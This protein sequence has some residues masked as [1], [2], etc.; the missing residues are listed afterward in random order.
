MG[1][2]L[3]LTIIVCLV[4]QLVQPVIS[5]QT[6][7]YN[8][9]EYDYRTA[10][11]L[12][13]KEK[14]TAAMELFGNIKETI[15]DK[16]H[17]M[18]A[19]CVY[20]I[21]VCAYELLNNDAEYKLTS[22]IQEF[23]E[24]AR[25][26]SARLY[27]ANLY[28]R[29]RKYKRA[30]ELYK[31][32]DNKMLHTSE[33]HEFFFKL[34]YSAFSEDDMNTA[35]FYF[36]K[37]KDTESIYASSATYYFAHIAYE[38]KNYNI[39][40]QHFRRL[41]TDETFKDIV[42]YYI[43]QILYF[44]KK[45]DEL[46]VYVAPLLQQSSVRRLPEILKLAAEAHFNL[47]QF[48]I[49]L[50]FFERYA[51]LSGR[52]TPEEQYKI[53][54]AYYRTQQFEEAIVPF[55]E[56]TNA[57]DSI[58]QNAHYHLGYCYIQIGNKQLARTAFHQ[59]YKIH[60]NKII[61]ED[62]L[63][64]FAKLSY[65]LGVNPYNEAIIA[66]MDYIERYPDSHRLDEA[67]EYL[68][69]LYFQTKNYKG[70]M[71]SIEKVKR[72]NEKLNM[73]YQKIAYFRGVELFNDRNYREAIEVFDKSQK[74]P[75]DRQLRAQ[76]LFWK[77]EA[78]YQLRE[79]D[80][81]IKGYTAF[82][83]S[84]GAF[85]SDLFLKAHYNLGYSY[86]NKKQYN[87]ALTHFRT[88]LDGSQQKNT[89]LVYDAFI[90]QGDCLYALQRYREAIASYERAIK[91]DVAFADYALLQ[92]GFTRG[93][94]SDHNGKISDLNE[95]IKLF[96]RSPYMPDVI[97]ELANTYLVI[98]NSNKAI[99]YYKQI[100]DRYPNSSYRVKS[101]LKIGMTYY[102][103][104]DNRKALEQL[105]DINKEYSGSP[106]SKEAL[107]IMRNIYTEMNQV[108]EFFVYVKDMSGTTVT[109]TEQDTISYIAAENAYMKGECVNARKGFEN[110]IK[111]FPNGQFLA[112]AY[113]Y[114]AECDY[115]AEKYTDALVG[116][117]YIIANRWNKF[118]ETSLLKAA[119]IHF[120]KTNW[121]KAGEYFS[122]LKEKAETPENIQI[123]RVG[124]MRSLYNLGQY[125]QAIQAAESL[126]EAQKPNDENIDEARSI[127]GKSAYKVEDISKAISVFNQQKRLKSEF[128]AEA[129]YYIALI[130]YKLGKYE[131]SERH[132]FE[133]I[134]TLPSYEYWIAKA[135]ILL[136]DN[137]VATD[138]IFQA[139]HTLKSVIDNY[140]GKELV[141]IALQKLKEIEEKEKRSIEQPIIEEI[142][143]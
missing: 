3:S 42:P 59:A 51:E 24:N 64:H 96:P 30:L 23:S 56:A 139:K 7:Y 140:D 73:I 102:N 84:P 40:L 39:A 45:F 133:L 71:A 27:L 68:V 108:E 63:F 97:F 112:N 103:L 80:N 44:Q 5:Q 131:D 91:P 29:D 10:V 101:M 75:Y 127:I 22:F 115:Q 106:E 6:A 72:P 60:K 53:G 37:V 13:H 93:I 57:N 76:A 1:K 65:E 121:K 50:P 83:G 124:Q 54:Y 117:E 109:V 99:E 9:P 135:F 123:G 4:L 46:V 62:A 33:Q 110:Y 25:T 92:K 77:A 12:F 79:F 130:H 138:N 90:R 49:A 98:Q 95:F 118:S 136:S 129:F 52:L 107:V 18:Y 100:I 86:Y 132:I 67:Y 125:T 126:L 94:L 17:L 8:N 20:H 38:E 70:A 55:Q 41:T 47:Q 137:Y 69:N 26:S 122:L 48:D 58:A 19:S 31:E 2:K 120:T 87:Q 113:F 28:Y 141:E 89:P 32:I 85:G 21:A 34:A 114:K 61:A 78:H 16:E 105:K 74:H 104:G 88:F 116:Y 111:N 14:F 15:S 134:N 43:S 11:D 143:E 66:I 119:R 35:S 81:A 82:L 142:E 36:S 128:G